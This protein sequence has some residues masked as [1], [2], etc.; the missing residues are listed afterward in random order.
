MTQGGIHPVAILTALAIEAERLPDPFA[1]R[2]SA[3]EARRTKVLAL[4][5]GGLKQNAIA[6]RLNVSSSLISQILRG[7]R[8]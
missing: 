4:K 7:T 1:R 3:K 2:S 8:S 6:A 5:A